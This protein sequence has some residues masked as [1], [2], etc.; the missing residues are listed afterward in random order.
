MGTAAALLH[1]LVAEGRRA[2]A[3]AVWTIG[4]DVP[5]EMIRAAGLV[6][7]PVQADLNDRRAEALL[8][9]AQGHPRVRALLSVLL[10]DGGLAS[11][12][13]LVSTT[14]SYHSVLF[15]VLKCLP[16]ARPDLPRYD[17]HLVD[18]QHGAL[19]SAQSYN[20]SALTSLRGTL[21]HWAG[22]TVGDD[23]L[24]LAID[25]AG[26]LR[27]CLGELRRLRAARRITGADALRVYEAGPWLED[28]PA[29]LSALLAALQESGPCPGVPVVYSGT[30]A[31]PETYAAIER[32]GY[33]IVA[34]DQDGADRVFGPLL[35]PSGQPMMRIALG[36]AHRAPSPARWTIEQRTRALLDRVR[37][38]GAEAV[39]FNIAAFEHPAAWDQP[40]QI[41]A[42]D[43]AGIPHLTLDSRSYEKPGG[44]TAQ[45]LA[46]H[47][48]SS[49]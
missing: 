23:S 12:R 39:I 19:S 3:G 1:R 13:L 47:G 43:A 36:Y 11:D 7:L 6:P 37:E 16:A 18:L 25:A 35:P 26:A 31:G 15:H 46:L 33:L 9:E 4:L 8:D 45:L 34:D 20:L 49:P 30:E 21:A 2:P 14:P 41:A 27:E 24:A 28:F 17:V 32:A 29:R 40:S 38:S 5:I 22:G 10:A 42:L 48:R 44:I